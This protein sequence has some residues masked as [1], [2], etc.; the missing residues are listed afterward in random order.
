MSVS[1]PP[2]SDLRWTPPPPDLDPEVSS[3]WPASL[4]VN[5]VKRRGPMLNARFVSLAIRCFEVFADNDDER[6][7][8]YARLAQ[9]A[10]YFGVPLQAQSWRELTRAGA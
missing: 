1:A 5:P 8:A 6:E 7:L 10:R 2:L 3:A 9:A 4:F